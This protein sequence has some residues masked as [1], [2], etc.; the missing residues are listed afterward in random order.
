[1]VPRFTT[2]TDI[3]EKGDVRKKSSIAST[4]HADILLQ[5]L[6]QIRSD[7]IQNDQS[8]PL[9][10]YHSC[11]LVN[12]H[13]CIITIPL[14]YK[15]ITDHIDSVN[16]VEILL[17]FFDK[18][19][20]QELIDLGIDVKEYKENQGKRNLFNYPSFIED[21]NYYNLTRMVDDYIDQ[22]SYELY[23]TVVIWI[24]ED[25]GD[26]ETN[27]KRFVVKVNF[28][29][30]DNS[31]S[32]NM[33]ENSQP[34]S[35]ITMSNRTL[36]ETTI[37][38]D[39]YTNIT[40]KPSTIRDQRLMSLVP[41]STKRN[42]QKLTS[43][44]IKEIIQIRTETLLSSI[45][46]VFIKYDSIIKKLTFKCF[47]DQE[48]DVLLRNKRFM[49]LLCENVN[50]VKVIA[51][52]GVLSR[53]GF[54]DAL[55]ESKNIK[56]LNMEFLN[57]ERTK[58]RIYQTLDLL[59]TSKPTLTTIHFTN[60]KFSRLINFIFCNS[61]QICHLQLTSCKFKQEDRFDC[62]FSCKNLLSLSFM[63]C[64]SINNYIKKWTDTKERAGYKI[65]E[66]IG[67]FVDKYGLTRDC[68][69]LSD[70][71]KVKV[72]EIKEA[73]TFS[74]QDNENGEKI[75]VDNDYGNFVN[76]LQKSEGFKNVETY[77]EKGLLMKI[78]KR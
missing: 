55:K 56:S 47:K 14:L 66:R 75:D 36:Y 27:M 7:N 62:I 37:F 20:I 17:K 9:Q 51:F 29:E 61:Q 74:E 28:D 50:E 25:K 76:W 63:C 18:E 43:S 15:S 64:K 8:N 34:N 70:S 5:I 22:K 33:E 26:K 16:F 78:F 3:P 19:Q 21:M 11:A 31:N 60:M 45:L 32:A 57:M 71:V 35:L 41:R 53:S 6:N 72:G 23:N 4:L 54:L 42:E 65:K 67:D 39:L 46:N 38:T 52:S 10:S 49:K 1:M 68:L 69:G 2:S 48:Y 30:K 12:K 24:S 44:I 59:M 13:W 77:Y 58:F 40:Y 73:W